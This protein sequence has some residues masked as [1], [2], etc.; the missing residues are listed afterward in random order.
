[1]AEKSARERI[2]DTAL[3]LFEKHGYHGVGIN[4]IIEESGTS[5]GGFYHNFKSKDELLYIIHD[6]FISYALNTIQNAVE[7]NATPTE[8]LAEILKTSSE[9]FTK[10][11]PHQTVFY[12]DHT[13]LPEA[14]FN[15]ISI[16]RDKVRDLINSVIQDGMEK[17]EFL[18]NLP[19]PII[20]MTIFGMVNWTYKWYK[21]EGPFTNEEIVTIY[22]DFTLNSLLT[23]EAKKN[24]QFSEFFLKETAAPKK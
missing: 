16:K 5:K 13:Y 8:Q 11:K 9:N 6:T 21:P 14:Y 15:A 3:A 10:Y 22:A 4:K 20:G 23:E 17:G 7:E 18:P 19:V 24:Y 2:I 12:Q 1:M